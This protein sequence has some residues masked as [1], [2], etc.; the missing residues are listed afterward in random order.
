[1]ATNLVRSGN[2]ITYVNPNMGNRPG[3]A[4]VFVNGI[5]NSRNEAE[6]S[7]QIISSTI[8]NSRVVLFYNPTMNTKGIYDI[9]VGEESNR[10]LSGELVTL[11]QQEIAQCDRAVQNQTA[12]RVERVRVLILAHSHGAILTRLAL[13]NSSLRQSNDNLEVAAFGGATLIPVSLARKVRNFINEKD[14]IPLLAMKRAPSST[15]AGLQ[16]F[17]ENAVP[18]F[19]R[20]IVGDLLGSSAY[21]EPHFA[22]RLDSAFKTHK[23][24]QEGRS[25]LQ[26]Q[27]IN[28]FQTF[29]DVIEE[30]NRSQGTEQQKVNKGILG[31][32]RALIIELGFDVEVLTPTHLPPNDPFHHPVHTYLNKITWVVNSS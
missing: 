3:E 1:M 9:S 24:I 32:I 15:A 22:D 12:Q 29:V 25:P 8:N 21:V 2:H 7:A 31:S 6:E 13:E 16:G 19:Q 26:A 30:A 23:L 5:C 17:I 14:F 20:I 4:I 10:A 27:L 28:L 18:E 11:I